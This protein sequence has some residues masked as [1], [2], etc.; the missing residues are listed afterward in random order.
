MQEHGVPVT[1]AYISDAHDKHPS[2]PAYGPGE[3]GYVAALKSYDDAFATF[4]SRLASDGITPANT[5]FVITSDENDHFVGGAPSNPG[6]DG[7]N[8]PCTYSHVNCPSTTITSCPPNN[9]GEINAN[10]AGLLA[11]EQGI[12]TPF[13]V[14]ADSAPNVYITGR[15][16]RTDPVARAFEQAT[17]KLTLTNPLTGATQTVTNY[18]AD[19]VEEQ[20]LHMV[21]ADPMR[22]PTFTL[23][24]NPDD[25]LYAGG[26]TCGP[27]CVQQEYGYA[28]NHG[29]VSPDINTTWLGLV[30]PG[31]RQMGVDNAV[32][33]DHTDVRPTMLALTG[34]QDDYTHDGRVLWEVLYDWA[35]PQS[36]RAHRE[37]ITRLAEAYKQ[38]DA[39]VG[40]FGLAT[41]AVS[42]RALAS[43][44]AGDA[45][46]T[47]LES[48]LAT[49]GGQRDAL[50]AQISGLLEGAE[51]GGQAVNEQQAKSLTAQAW[52]LISEAQTKAGS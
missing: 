40:D 32:W 6:C 51:F 26:T 43:D 46:Y 4:F 25:Y 47:Q 24:A 16:S 38:L 50:A 29:D 21:T 11:S 5:L 52:A 42:T 48:W 7:V 31:V 3:A 10:L 20:I 39:A 23:F 22:T 37:T 13:A 12:T 44:S 18:L 35:V 2:G 19:P 27:T 49:I 28:W 8:I 17:S 36:L 30:G 9:V 45:T 14:H 41:L 34:L 1:Y 33:S 15:P